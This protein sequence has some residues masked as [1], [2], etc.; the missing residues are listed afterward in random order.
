MPLLCDQHALFSW[1]VSKV[2]GHETRGSY[3]KGHSINNTSLNTCRSNVDVI[4]D[5]PPVRAIFISFAALIWTVSVKI[6][7]NFMIAVN[8]FHSVSIQ[9]LIIT[10][11]SHHPCNEMLACG[12]DG[13]NAISLHVISSW[14]AYPVFI[15]W[16]LKKIVYESYMS[17]VL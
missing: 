16:M 11:I 14:S 8:S 2:K 13:N 10:V 4:S 9:N 15:Q 12:K 3:Q 7:L 17:K 1:V 6:C 5:L